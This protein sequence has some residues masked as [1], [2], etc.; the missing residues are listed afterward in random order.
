MKLTG[1]VG[2]LCF[3]QREGNYYVRS[4]SSLCGKRVKSDPAFGATMW[5]A[6]LLGKSARIAS[7]IYK[8]LTAVQ[9][10]EWPYRKLTGQVM[11]L[12]R[13]ETAENTIIEL[14]KERTG[15]T[16]SAKNQ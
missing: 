6:A 12:L 10:L 1:T 9:K 14:L 8:R 15:V 2:T 5:Y 11:Q 7:G 3:Y 4:K 13:Q 16:G